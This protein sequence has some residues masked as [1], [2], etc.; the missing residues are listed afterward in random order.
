[1][2]ARVYALS[3]Q[4]ATTCVL[5]GFTVKVELLYYQVMYVDYTDGDGCSLG[6]GLDDQLMKSE[7]GELTTVSQVQGL[8]ELEVYCK[9]IHE[10]EF[11]EGDKSYYVNFSVEW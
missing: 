4:M 8:Q 3:P 9:F 5:W 2:S 1:M 11:A 7:V 10:G 6:M